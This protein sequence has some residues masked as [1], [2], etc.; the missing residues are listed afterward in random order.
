MHISFSAGLAGKKRKM[1]HFAA[2][3]FPLLVLEWW[4]GKVSL[5]WI[6]AIGIEL[7]ILYGANRFIIGSPSPGSWVGAIL[8]IYISQLSFGLVN[9]VEAVLFPYIIGAPILYLLIIA[10]TAASFGICAACYTIIVRSISPEEISQIA[11][12]GGLLFPVVFFF[13]AELHIMQTS[14]TQAFYNDLS[15]VFFLENAGRHTALLFLQI[16]GL[17]SLFCTLYAYR[18]LYRSL[19]AQAQIQSLAQASQ[20]Q[21][22]YVAEAKMRY[23]Q[24]RAFRHDIK[25]HLSVLNGLLNS[26]KLEESKAYLLKLDAAST[27]LSFPYQ[28]GNPVVD[29]LLGEKLELAKAKGIAAEVSLVIPWPCGIDDFDLCV[30]FANALDNAVCACQSVKGTKSIVIRGKR[31]GDFYMLAFEN[32]CSDRPL[33]P[34]GTGLSNIRSVAEKYHGAMLTEK[35]GHIFSLNVLLDISLHPEDSSLQKP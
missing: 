2:Y 12:A 23:E 29:I 19:Q 22:V 33:P 34:P 14:Y 6:A 27:A 16:L 32:T 1:W 15:S 18:H 4:A 31:Q 3:I 7:L 13:T 28:T 26:G 5:P 11:K 20:A 30:I 8:S 9:S 35:A 17:A 25:N 10:S 21:K 24:T